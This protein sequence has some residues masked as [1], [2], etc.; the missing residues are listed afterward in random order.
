MSL[1]ADDT[2][3]NKDRIIESFPEI[4]QVTQSCMPNCSHSEASCA[5]NAWIESDAAAKSERLIRVT[6]LRSLLEVKPADEER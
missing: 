5:L 4:Y 2:P 6:S 3:L 1:G